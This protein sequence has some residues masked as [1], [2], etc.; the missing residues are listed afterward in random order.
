MLRSLKTPVSFCNRK[1][2]V[3]LPQKAW[4]KWRRTA[5]FVCLEHKAS[6]TI[7]DKKSNIPLHLQIQASLQEKNKQ[8]KTSVHLPK[9]TY[10]SLIQNTICTVWVDEMANC[11]RKVLPVSEPIRKLHSVSLHN[12]GTVPST[13]HQPW[14]TPVTPPN[15]LRN[16]SQEQH[17]QLCWNEDSPW[18]K[19]ISCH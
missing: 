1:S 14:G 13:S 15:M 3:T 19:T 11:I 4:Q 17:F 9:A 8:K 2:L 18:A 10:L 5:M 16:S 7:K 12:Q 6:L